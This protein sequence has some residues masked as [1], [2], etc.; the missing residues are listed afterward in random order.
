M[1]TSLMVCL[2]NIISF[3]QSNIKFIMRFGFFNITCHDRYIASVMPDRFKAIL[4]LCCVFRTV[5]PQ[6]VISPPVCYAKRSN[7]TR[8]QKMF[9]PPLNSISNR[10]RKKEVGFQEVSTTKAILCRSRFLSANVTKMSSILQIQKPNYLSWFV[11]Y[12]GWNNEISWQHSSRRQV[13]F[14]IFEDSR[15]ELISS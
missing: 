14:I 8:I 4:S 10:M 13:A 6:L 12:T 5:S 7:K 9:F 15:L 2:Q 1:I 11:V 3:R